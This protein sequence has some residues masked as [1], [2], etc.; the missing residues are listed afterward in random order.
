MDWFLR[1]T[2]TANERGDKMR[3][4][5]GVAAMV[6]LAVAR[7]ASGAPGLA[8]PN[9]TVGRNLE[10]YGNVRLTEAAPEGGV[11]IVLTS[12][13]PTRLLLSDS[14]DKAGTASV[15]LTVRPRAFDSPEFCV[16]GLAD[17]GAVTYT[18]TAEGVGTATGTVTLAPSAIVIFGPFKAPSFPTTPRSDP[19]KITIVAVALDPEM[20]ILEEQQIAG[21]SPLEVSISN[22]ASQAGTVDA[23][24]LTLAGGT[25]SAGT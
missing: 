2:S 12:D 6:V 3:Y 17:H 8:A 13:D 11:R 22:S 10:T 21:G 4:F 20:K 16:Q 1:F 15:T 24:K 18:A 19:F 5:L 23:S 25:T 14:L 7:P 9:L